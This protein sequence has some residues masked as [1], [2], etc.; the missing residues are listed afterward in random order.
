MPLSEIACA[1]QRPDSLYSL[2]HVVV[3]FKYSVAPAPSSYISAPVSPSIPLFLKVY[4]HQ[5]LHNGNDVTCGSIA[6]ASCSI[7]P[8]V[9]SSDPRSAVLPSDNTRKLQTTVGFP[10]GIS[11]IISPVMP[12]PAFATI[13]LLACS[14]SAS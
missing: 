7:T 13:L 3:G 4:E 2:S 10:D 14:S 6:S 8:V 11:L 12:S 5:G 1:I 9:E